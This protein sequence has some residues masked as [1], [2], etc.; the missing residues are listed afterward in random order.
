MAHR[1]QAVEAAAEAFLD[2]SRKYFED[3]DQHSPVDEAIFTECY[4]YMWQHGFA[5][6]NYAPDAASLE[7]TLKKVYSRSVLNNPK[8]LEKLLTGPANKLVDFCRSNTT[9]PTT[10][11]SA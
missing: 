2:D 5:A 1:P 11:S 8:K 6:N 7:N 9:R 10:T 3:F 4:L